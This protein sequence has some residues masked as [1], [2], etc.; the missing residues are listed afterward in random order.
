MNVPQFVKDVTQIVLRGD[1]SQDVQFQQLDVGWLVDFAV[2][3]LVIVLKNAVASPASYLF[4][5]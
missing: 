5:G 4:L 2:E 3:L 1:L